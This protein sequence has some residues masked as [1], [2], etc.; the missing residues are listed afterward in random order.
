VQN[1]SQETEISGTVREVVNEH[2]TMKWLY[3]R[4]IVIYRITGP[5]AVQEVAQTWFENVKATIDAWPADTMYLAVHDAIE[6]NFTI[7]PYLT[8]CIRDIVAFRRDLPRRV[9]IVMPREIAA[10]LLRTL[11]RPSDGD[12][13]HYEVF[14]TREEAMRWLMGE[15][16]KYMMQSS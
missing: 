10:Q 14:S 6:A 7:T 15:L 11:L 16:Y 2:L 4:Q 3:Q 1:S 13:A 8:T 12:N 5:L 9:A